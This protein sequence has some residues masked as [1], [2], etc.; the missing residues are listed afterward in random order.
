MLE[1]KEHPPHPAM[2]E[3]CAS[4]VPLASSS[5]SSVL[6]VHV[7]PFKARGHVVASMLE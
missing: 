4:V 5:V 7:A 1:T 3:F 6:P 2:L